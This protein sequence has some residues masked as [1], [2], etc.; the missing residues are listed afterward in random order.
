M[1]FTY[2]GKYGADGMSDIP[3]NKSDIDQS[4]IFAS[5]FVPVCIWVENQATKK[6]NWL[7]VNP[8]VNSWTSVTYLRIA[9][10]K[11]TKGM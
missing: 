10:E 7:Y 11:E 8:N 1:I 6:K 2:S 4:S 5:A 3:H 9:H